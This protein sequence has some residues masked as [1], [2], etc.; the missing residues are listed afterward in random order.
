MGHIMNIKFLVILILPLA[1]E[2][3]IQSVAPTK[4]KST[5]VA[6]STQSK[7]PTTLQSLY[8]KLFTSSNSNAPSAAQKITSTTQ[9][10]MY[11]NT[12]TQNNSTNTTTSSSIKS[13]T[14]SNSTRSPLHQNN[15]SAYQAFQ[16][17]NVRPSATT[18]TAQSVLNSAKTALTSATQSMKN[19]ATNSYN[20]LKSIQ[21]NKTG[22]Q[23][24]LLS[25][26]PK[27]DAASISMNNQNLATKTTTGA[28]LH[29]SK[30]STQ[31]NSQ[32]KITSETPNPLQPRNNSS[33][34]SLQLSSLT[35]PSRAQ[36]FLNNVQ[37]TASNISNSI[38]STASSVTNAFKN[39][40]SS[41]ANAL[42]STASRASNAMQF[43]KT[44]EQT[45]LLEQN[46]PRSDAPSQNVQTSYST[47]N[48]F[49][50]NPLQLQEVKL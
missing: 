3:T 40:A 18:S 33:T 28:N 19:A 1:N 16:S 10:P 37:A 46:Q 35:T 30:Q 43:N 32:L 4:G 39:T 38:Q 20:S 13:S 8:N 25:G 44:G 14:S 31:N 50:I 21:F 22:E 15:N 47:G 41:A 11:K 45:R 5:Q 42:Q 7:S 12:T 27:S 49:T 24:P 6:S 48:S 23:A 9:N 36:N 29:S 2:L 34:Q 26:I 17:T